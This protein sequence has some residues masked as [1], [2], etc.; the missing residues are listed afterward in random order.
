MAGLHINS[1]IPN[2]AFQ[3][4]STAIGGSSGPGAS[5][6]WYAALTS[7]IDTDIDFAGFVAGAGDAA[8]A[9]RTAW[10]TVGVT[11]SAAALSTPVAGAGTE[12]VHVSRSGGF[13]RL[14]VSG[15]VDLTGT[16]SRAERQ[17]PGRPDRL[18]P[19]A[20]ATPAVGHVCH[21]FKAP[22]AHRVTWPS[23]TSP[24]T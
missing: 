4:V 14:L 6:I 16:E 13:A 21:E 10:Q 22:P 8:D 12:Q 17:N 3:L 15:A 5:R 9:F 11:S 23:R 2:R 20:P 24:T 1:G 7:C 18:H 19:G